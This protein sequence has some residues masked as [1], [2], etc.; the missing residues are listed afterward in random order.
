MQWYEAGIEGNSLLEQNGTE[1][2]VESTDTLVLED[3]AGTVEETLGVGRL[4]DKTDTGGLEGAEGN[5]SEELGQTGRGEV[6]GGAVLGGSLVAKVVD[7]LLLEVFVST[8][9]EGTLEEVTS[10][11]RAETSEESASTLALDDLAEATDHA[12]VV[13]GGVKLD[14]GLDA[15]IGLVA[16]IYGLL[17]V[18]LLN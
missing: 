17:Y 14:T 9:L 4:S 16:V 15:G 1:T 7:G 13:G 18:W 2:G 6:D 8:E 10:S 11:G 12:T 5:V 3:L